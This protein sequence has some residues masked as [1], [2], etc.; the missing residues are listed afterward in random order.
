MLKIRLSRRG[1]KKQPSYRVVVADIN[2][3]RDGRIVERIGHYNPLTE[4]AEFTIKEDRALHWLSVGAQPTDAVRRLLDKQ[5]TFDRLGR[6]RAGESLDVLA[7]EV[8]GAVVAAPEAVEE[9]A[10]AEETAEEESV[11]EKVVDA[12]KDAAADAVEK[13]EE[14]VEAVAEAVEDV[15]DGDDDDEAD[16][17]EAE[18]EAAEAADDE[19][20]EEA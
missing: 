8:S 14:A 1:K 5:G 7:A 16:E 12:V 20:E 9:V 11:V 17:A 18:E 10:E 19:D 13:V 15:V 3:K 2:A 4:P 6:M